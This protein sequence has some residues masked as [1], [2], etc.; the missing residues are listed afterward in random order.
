MV[1]SKTLPVSNQEGPPEEAPAVVE[2]EECFAGE[3]KEDYLETAVTVLKR[4]NSALLKSSL[5]APPMRR[6]VRTTSARF[7]KR[8]DRYDH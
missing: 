5:H 8:L 2:E 4:T 1:E 3:I 7:R 6:S